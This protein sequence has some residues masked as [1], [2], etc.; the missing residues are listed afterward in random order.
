MWCP[1][2]VRC[3]SIYRRP[4]AGNLEC[5][6][7][8]MATTVEDGIDR[9]TRVRACPRPTDTRR[10]RPAASSRGVRVT[11]MDELTDPWKSIGR[12]ASP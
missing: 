3:C 1:E 9:G 6:A 5:A 8:H 11:E 12:S 10:A 4:R 2:D 7:L